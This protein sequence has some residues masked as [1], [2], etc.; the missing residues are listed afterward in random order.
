[1]LVYH[2]I[3]EAASGLSFGLLPVKKMI[4]CGTFDYGKVKIYMSLRR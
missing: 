2:K 4:L 3:A 1:M